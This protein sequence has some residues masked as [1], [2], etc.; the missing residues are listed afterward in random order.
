MPMGLKELEAEALR[1]DPKARARLAGKLLEC[2]ENLSEEE[3][4]RLWAEEAQRERRRWM[5]IRTLA[6]RREKYSGRRGPPHND[7]VFADFPGVCQFEPA[8]DRMETGWVWD[9]KETNGH[10]YDI[11]V[12]S[13]ENR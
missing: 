4:M 5:P 3:N 10:Q 6:L 2:L 12:V 11:A 1:L 13:R 7:P 8:L 9:L